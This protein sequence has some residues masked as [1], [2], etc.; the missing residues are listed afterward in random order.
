M[1]KLVA[2]GAM[3]LGIATLPVTAAHAKATW[4]V[5]VQASRTTVNVGQKV[6]FTGS[7]K[8]GGK[9]AG[10]KVV[11]QERFKPGAKWQDQSKDKV[12]G[13]GR[14]TLSDKPSA[15]TQHAYRVVMPA[16]G[17]HSK[18]V[19]RTIKVTVYDWVALSTLPNVNQDGLYFGSV[20]INGKTYDD[21]VRSDRADRTASVEVNLGHKCDAMRSTFG[22]ADYSTTGGQAE[23][24]VLSDG[25]SVYDKVFDLEQTEQKTISLETPLKLKLTATDTNVDPDIN[26]FGA[27]GDAQAHCTK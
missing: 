12:N 3:A 18:G 17:K 9:A 2:A 16:A 23:V 5:T 6:T 21:S 19:S 27:F 1:R 15:N 10:L 11:L 7:V 13:K 14:Y 20:D 8:P 26:G 24:G 4:L 22:L 25:T